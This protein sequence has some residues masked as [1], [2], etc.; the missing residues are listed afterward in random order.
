MQTKP[1][2]D[3]DK[4]KTSRVTRNV[5]MHELLIHFTR[6][7]D[8]EERVAVCRTRL[9]DIG[10]HQRIEAYGAVVVVVV[11]VFGGAAYVI[12]QCTEDRSDIPCGRLW[13]STS[14]N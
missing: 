13:I 9:L 7:E 6:F 14:T 5:F 8:A 12:L 11:V 1:V 2:H 3:L 4:V 10:R